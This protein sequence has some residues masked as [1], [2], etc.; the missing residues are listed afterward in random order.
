MREGFFVCCAA[1]PRNRKF[2]S[3]FAKFIELTTLKPDTT[4]AEV[5]KFTEDAIRFNFAGVCIPPLY[6]RE[7][8]R[9]L[10]ERAKVKLATAVG[11][12]LGYAA[13]SAKSD[14]IKRAME[15][16]ADEINAVLNISAVKSGLWNHVHRDIDG[17]VLATRSRGGILK[18]IIEEY[19]LTQT[20]LEKICRLAVETEVPWLAIGTGMFSSPPVSAASIQKFCLMAPGLKIMASSAPANISELAA[21]VNAGAAR[22]ALLDSKTAV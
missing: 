2:M 11:F 8:R 9:I 5:Q 14:E 13:I 20:E 7:S 3:E 6:I 16:G 1:K 17:L 22:I 15:E 4:L 19:L 21:L 10:G 12:P 18:L